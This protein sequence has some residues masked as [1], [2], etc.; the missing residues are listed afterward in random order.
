VPSFRL[1]PFAPEH[2]GFSLHGS[3]Q[4]AGLRLRVEYIL[5]GE[6][7]TLLIPEPTPQ[8]Q[9]RDGL[10]RSTCFELFVAPKAASRYLEINV[11]PSGDWNAYTFSAYR[12]G[13][14]P[15]AV[16]DLVSQCARRDP[17]TLQ[18]GFTLELPP[19]QSCDAELDVAVT[20]VL[21]HGGET[22]SYWALVHNGDRP[23]FHNRDSFLLSLPIHSENPS[24]SPTP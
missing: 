8:R 22:R 17:D 11:S 10:W 21:E 9:R 19:S 4:R 13:L 15:L 3:V 5:S 2:P 24:S 16:T 12:E 14:A 7:S 20:A 23:D 6:L 1:I 18:L